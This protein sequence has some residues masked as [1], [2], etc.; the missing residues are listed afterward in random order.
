MNYSYLVHHFLEQSARLYPDKVALIHEDVRATYAQINARANQLTRLLLDRGIRHGDRVVVLLEN[1]LEYVVSYYGV[2]KAGAVAVPLSTDLKP[3]SLGPLLGEIEPKA[4]ISSSRFERL[5][6]AT[7]LAPFPINAVILKGPNLTWSSA[8]FPLVPWEDVIRDEESPNIDLPIQESALAGIIYTSGST[9]KPKGAMLSHRNIVSNTHS[10]CQ[11]LHLNDKDI[12]MVVLPFYYVM[13]K[14]LL[15][16]HVAAGGTVV[17][18]NKFAF[19]ASVIK[20]MVD[21]HVTGF[22]GVP[23]TYAYLLHRSPLAKYRDKLHSLRYCAQAGGH[24]SRAIKEQLRQVLPSHTKIYIMY[25][26]TEAAARITYLEPSQFQAAI[27]S[28]GKPIPGVRLQVLDERG[29]DVPTGQV[30][31]LRIGAKYNA[32]LLEGRKSHGGSAR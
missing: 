27:D 26:A 17:I 1:C 10:I 30:G 22:S 31:E 13:G 16:T 28:I 9:G 20:Q 14:S 2:L 15:N 11:Y 7:D 18:N 25:G 12:Q 24:M 19:P 3:D 32:G 6:Q 23:S 4:I 8:P 29:E 5:L 21:E